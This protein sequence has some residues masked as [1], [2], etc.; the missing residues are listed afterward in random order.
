MTEPITLERA[1]V[2]KQ[3]LLR[4]LHIENFVSM[5][6]GKIGDDHAIMIGVTAPTDVPESFDGVPVIVEVVDLPRPL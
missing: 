6:I 4:S 1:S 2:A 5:G 3:K